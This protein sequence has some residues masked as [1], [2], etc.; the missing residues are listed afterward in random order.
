VFLFTS[1]TPAPIH[2]PSLLFTVLI[3]FFQLPWLAFFTQRADHGR[4]M[5]I[6]WLTV[7][8][9][10]SRTLFGLRLYLSVGA[11]YDVVVAIETAGK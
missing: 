9:V 10:V 11:F 1:L 7:D 6:D 2:C 3:P 5:Q 4:V 8:G